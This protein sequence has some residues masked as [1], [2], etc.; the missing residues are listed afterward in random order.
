MNIGVKENTVQLLFIGSLI[1][2]VGVVSLF[3]WPADVTGATIRSPPCVVPEDDMMIEQSMAFCT[4]TYSLPSGIDIAGAG[5]TVD[6]NNAVLVGN[7]KG[8]GIILR[9]NGII[10]KDCILRAYDTAVD[11]RGSGNQ[12]V[13]VD[14]SSS[15]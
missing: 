14:V 11:D 8:T 10:V 4:G 12:L 6:C 5:V 15:S 2:L 1:V 3:K 13:H 7:G 9:E